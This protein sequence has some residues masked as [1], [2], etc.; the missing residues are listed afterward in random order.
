MKKNLLLI[1]MLGLIVLNS[2][3]QVANYSY[4]FASNTFD[5][6]NV[7]VKTLVPTTTVTGNYYVDSTATSGSATVTKGIGL[8]IGFTFTYNGANFNV[9]GLQENGWIS[10][11]QDSVNM[12]T[13]STTV[14][15]SATST[16]SAALQNR[17]CALAHAL[18]GQTTGAQLSYATIGTAPYRT[19]VIEWKRF[20]RSTTTTTDNI[21]FQI[22]L[23]ETYN[24]IKFVYGTVTYTGT[25]GTVQVGLRGKLNTDFNTRTSTNGWTSTTAGTAAST[26]SLSTTY[27]PAPGLTYIFTP[28][29]QLDAGISAIN[30]PVTSLV[31]G[32]TKI[33]ATI[34]SYGL[35]SIASTTI[36]WSVNGVLQPSYS[37]SGSKIGIGKTNG[38]D[39][40]GMYNFLNPG[41]YTLK[42]WTES[43][44]G[45]TDGNHA[46]DTT[47]K[48]VYV[49]GYASLPFM[50]NFDKIW[51]T[52]TDEVPS[53][54]W[55]NSPNTGNSSWRRDDDGAS[56]A[57]TTPT[58]G[59]YAPTGAGSGSI[60]HSARF[61]STSAAAGTPGLFDLYM[62]FST[63][64]SK[65]LKFHHINTS[66]NDSLSIYVS[67]D[68]G[69]TFNFVQ[70]ITTDASWIQHT[71]NLGSS[72]S[73]K[74][75][76]RFKGVSATTTNDFGIDSVQVY[77]LPTNDAGVTAINSPS[78]SLVAG[79]T[80]IAVTIANYGADTLRT[81]N[82]AWSVNGVSQTSFPWT[83]KIAFNATNGP[84]TIGTYNFTTPGLYTIKV[85]AESPNGSSDGNHSND[86]TSKIVYVVGYASIPFYESFNKTWITPTYEVP[87]IYWVN[88]PATGNNSWRRNDEGV[89]ASWTNITTGAYTPTGV[90]S[91]SSLYSA[92]FHSASA[93]T[94]SPNNIGTLDAYIDFSTVGTKLLKF[95]HINT[96]GTDTL[97]V[98]LSNDGG[99][100]FNLIQKFATTANT[101]WAQH[102]V[103]LGTS[104]AA[105]SIVR[106][107][108][109]N[110]STNQATDVGID[111]VQV[112]MKPANDMAATAWLAPLNGC[113]HTASDTVTIRIKNVGDAV[114][115]SIPVKY[116]I[117]GGAT[118]VSETCTKTVNPGDSLNYTFAQHANFATPKAYSCVGIVNLA[119][120]A[121]LTNDT[122]KTT[123]NTFNTISGNPFIDSLEA[124]NL[125]YYLT[126]GANAAVAITAAVG[127][128]STH[129]FDMTG[130]AQ[131]NWPS[132][133]SATTTPQQAF[134]YTDH[135]STISTCIDASA[136]TN[137]LYLSMDLKQTHSQTTGNKYSYFMVLVNGKDTISDITG[138]KFFNATTQNAD[139]FA[140]KVFNLS[141]YKGTN[142]SLEFMAA[143]KY[144][145]ANIT[146]ADHV[147]LDNIALS[148]KPIVNLGSDTTICPNS[149]IVLNAGTSP[150]NYLYSYA[151]S[152]LLH[153]ATIATTQTIAA[154]SAA[155]YIATVNNGYGVTS[156]DTIVI[157]H[158]QPIV[159]SLGHDTTNCVSYTLDPGTGY[160]SYSWSTGE[161]SHAITVTSTGTYW[162][163]VTGAHGCVA[164]DSAN[165]TI[166]PM[167]IAYAG[168]AQSICYLDTL[169]LVGSSASFQDSVLW[170]SKG[171]GHFNDSTLLHPK[172]IF[173]PNDIS[174]KSVT[175][176]LVAYAKCGTDTSKTVITIT[177]SANANAGKDTAI[178][179]GNSV[180]LLATGGTTY[181]WRPSAGLSDTTIAN[182]IAHPTVTTAYVV[183]VTSSC[184]IATDTVV[185]KVDHITVPNLGKD[186][187]LC[188]GGAILLNAGSGYNSYA[189]S[190][191]ATTQSINYSN[192]GIGTFPVW[193][194]VTHGACSASDTI[195][196]KVD[197][198]TIPNLGKD[199]TF[200]N[201]VSVL[202]NAGAGYD[203]YLWSTG[204]TTQSISYHNTNGTFHVWVEV[205]HGAC[206]AT[207]TINLTYTSCVGI[208]E[209]NGNSFIKIFPNPSTGFA[210]IEVNGF[211]D[212]TYISI[213]SLQG[214][215]EYTNKVSDNAT[216]SVDLTNLSKG[217]YMVRVYN[218][219]NSILSKLILQ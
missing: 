10:L 175:L 9:F 56:A 210:N 152:T 91:A 199:T 25:N 29:F 198:I 111:S 82:I 51:V 176:A 120:D 44:N 45:S 76:V 110:V 143:C 78:T 127:T 38:P 54:Y 36:A 40:I 32:S 48:I 123:I 180:Q 115:S 151:W 116:T 18:V 132:G 178:C 31:N 119:Q 21:N 103:T 133:S 53:I 192:T 50:E 85:W 165:V 49:K 47:S 107:S 79:S 204:A 80:K 84:D 212:D 146:P 20:R 5:T 73:P 77:V 131:G 3:A 162:V 140:K 191:G 218:E 42:A 203:K 43:P 102:L 122:I 65:V 125:H 95:W 108:V 46:N 61:H 55:T 206:T 16:A 187:A 19:L 159:V 177:T 98:F 169:D 193:I 88:T 66:G 63:V 174:N 164:R 60:L 215:L 106:F 81:A 37:W 217:I 26:I 94:T 105:N 137:N 86:T 157:N 142:F 181:L 113:G 96:T 101:T 145:D 208:A 155:T 99:T 200:C 167:P 130:G 93:G 100:T 90:G 67:N 4:S 194:D 166:I 195:N 160:S 148:A 22:R 214:K 209:I 124:G 17:I 219:K 207:D 189:W 202:L 153:P 158:Y 70:K 35:D 92:R 87:S 117:D 185:V 59:A 41:L 150:F 11:G 12:N 57:W 30:S 23:N 149:S 1:L 171:D 104:T 97:S 172:Y 183:K 156:S 34:K 39:S 89:T 72:T 147:Y 205:T 213:Y 74:S 134:S 118:F 128:S 58:T 121:D 190:T 112:Y 114:Q 138:T 52:G 136:F 170:I 135:V 14:P 28:P 33:T 126:Y 196:V 184:G 6:L 141:T 197:D 15:I 75:I 13:S 62:N 163:D 173:G 129:G 109:K 211:T 69:A 216:I 186:T 8:P 161:T 139:P 179:L 2:N 71:L 201:N 27:L 188:T 154:D 24:T 83:G 168:A 144:S 7:P 64:G 68:S 182:P